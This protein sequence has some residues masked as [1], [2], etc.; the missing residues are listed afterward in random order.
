L[1]ATT[2]NGDRLTPSPGLSARRVAAV[3]IGTT[4]EIYDFCTFA[5]FAIQIGRSFFPQSWTSHG[6]L[7]SLASF[8]IGFITR[9]LGGIVIGRY[10]DRVGRTSAM[11]WSFGMM[12]AA[13]LGLAL[14][15][16][17][18]QIGI[19]APILLVS[20]RLVQGFALGGEVGPSVAYLIESAP[21]NRRG[22]YVGMLIATYS[23]ATL[24]A[25]L[26]GFVL[27]AWLQPAQLDDW[28]WRI[29]FL[30]GAAVVPVGLYI[31]RSLPDTLHE[32]DERVVPLP[33]NRIPP[34]FIVLSLMMVLA[35][36]ISSYVVD[37]MTTYAQDT[38]KLAARV[39]FG[40]T[41]VTGVCFPIAAAIGGSIS[42]RVG[43]KP[44]MTWGFGL[45]L[46]LAVPLFITMSRMPSQ[47]VVYGSI[48]ILS[49]LQ[50]LI[51]SMVMLTISESLPLSS[52][53]G[54]FGIIY[55]VGAAVFGGST[56][57]VIKWLIDLSGS[58]LAPAWYLTG[59]LLIGGLA[60]MAMR[61]SAPC[62]RREDGELK[63]RPATL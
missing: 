56:Q 17:Y 31:R 27:A 13:I 16:S 63:V 4:L 58:P 39:A 21:L 26:V 42:D 43:R 44:V 60:M 10:G 41:I 22:A 19:A 29:A 53:S 55:A 38:L 35:G 8:G 9:P 7:F 34:R 57:F 51:A 52:R 14:T 45:M 61:E 30:I 5:Y 59:A 37:Y 6:L 25:G 32:A 23:V 50:A 47:A 1:A 24:L 28:G 54:A 49:G 12:G 15:P 3:S 36:T 18:A 40:A 62:Q 46:V 48:A 2:L 20:F 11:L 33:R